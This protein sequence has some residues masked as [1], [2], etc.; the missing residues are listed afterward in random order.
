[1]SHDQQSSHQKEKTKRKRL[2]KDGYD[3]SNPGYYCVTICTEDRRLWL[4]E[5]VDAKMHLNGVGY[6]VQSIWSDL[7]ERFPGIEL[8]E[9]I[10]MP[11]HLHGI[12][13]LSE[14]FRKRMRTGNEQQRMPT[15]SQIVRAFKGAATRQIHVMGQPN[16]SWQKSFHERIIRD[17]TE[18]NIKREYLINNPVR[19][20]ENKIHFQS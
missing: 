16:F 4:G 13:V 10:I 15:L 1:M 11:N 18:L 14:D 20:E 19:W 6:I 3:Y 12:I 5:I 2:R 7:Y 8:D 9:Y 17:Q